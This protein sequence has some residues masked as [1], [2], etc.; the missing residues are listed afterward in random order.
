MGTCLMGIDAGGGGVRCL[1]VD[2]DGTQRA[3][4]E[5]VW[6]PHPDLSAGPFALDLDHAAFRRAFIRAVREATARSGVVP[7]DVAAIGVTGMR[8]STVLLN[9]EGEVLF[10][11]PNRDGRAASESSELA[12]RYGWELNQRTGHWPFPASMAARLI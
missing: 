2:Q 11:V 8:L 5:R 7:R 1:V 6:S 12:Q 10:A 3:S 9:G 4:A